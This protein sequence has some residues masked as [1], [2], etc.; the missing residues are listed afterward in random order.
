MLKLQVSESHPIHIVLSFLSQI[1]CT[2]MHFPG[3]W[4]VP[5]SLRIM[6]KVQMGDEVWESGG[7]RAPAILSAFIDEEL[8][9]KCI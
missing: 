4:Y 6:E 9:T 7:G 1:V 3:Y 5:Q 2:V 8:R